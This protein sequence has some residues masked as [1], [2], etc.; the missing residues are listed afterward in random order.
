M[1]RFHVSHPLSNSFRN[2]LAVAFLLLLGALALRPGP[3]TAAPAVN[4]I[5]PA[6]PTTILND[7]GALCALLPSGAVQCWG[8]EGVQPGPYVAV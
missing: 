5:I 4:S 8:V 2:G 7:G 6:G 3:A 1:M